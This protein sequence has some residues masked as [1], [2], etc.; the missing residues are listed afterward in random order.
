MSRKVKKDMLLI[1]KA[2]GDKVT[3]IGLV[4]I[5]HILD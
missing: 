4:K 1:S 2:K 5:S 3:E